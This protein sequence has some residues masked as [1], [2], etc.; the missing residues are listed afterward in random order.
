QWIEYDL[1][2]KF[3]PQFAAAGYRYRSH[4]YMALKRYDD[5]IND[6]NRAVKGDPKNS[7]NYSSLAEIYHIRKQFDDE[8][9]CLTEC[10]RLDGR[11][12]LYGRR[13]KAYREAKRYDLS[14]KDF[15]HGIAL[16]P[17]NTVLLVER[18]QLYDLMGKHALAQQDRKKAQ[19]LDKGLFDKS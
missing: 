19:E 10:I 12:A 9:R 17:Q 18:A 8:A 1:S 15:T 7:G 5:A 14:L 11:D 16:E 6:L 2:R 13:A 3:P 4:V